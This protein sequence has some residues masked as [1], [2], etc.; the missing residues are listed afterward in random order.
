MGIRQSVGKNKKS[1]RPVAGGERQREETLRKAAE[2]ARRPAVPGA[3]RDARAD[4]R[5]WP[6]E[7]D[8]ARCS[9]GV[10]GS[11]RR[12]AAVAFVDS[13]R[14]AARGACDR[15][16]RRGAGASA[17]PGIAAGLGPRRA[18]GSGG[19]ARRRRA[20]GRAER[21]RGGRATRLGNAGWRAS[22]RNAAGRAARR[23][24]ARRRR[25]MPTCSCSE[26]AASAASSASLLGSVADAAT[27]ARRSRCSS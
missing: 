11:P 1:K 16:P 24:A 26:R 22:G 23:A 2:A 27:S 21:R 25:P 15:A 8:S 5:R 6:V 7:A 12:A 18:R 4:S 20:P 17:V 13:S 10:D 3:E 9:S 19:G 14:A